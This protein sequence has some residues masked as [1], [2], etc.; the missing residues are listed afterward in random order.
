MGKGL[1]FFDSFHRSSS[2]KAAWLQK[3]RDG[4][5]FPSQNTPPQK[6]A[7]ML[8]DW[9]PTHL[10]RWPGYARSPVS[11]L[12]PTF[13]SSQPKGQTQEQRSHVW[14]WTPPPQL[15]QPPAVGIT[16]R[17]SSWLRPQA[18]WSNDEPPHLNGI[19]IK[20]LPHKIREPS[21]MVALCY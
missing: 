12:I 14:K 2:S 4:R 8:W 10:E 9:K 15:C 3:L 16:T 6:P 11:Q 21:E 20:F 18:S 7:V 5:N 1:R 17:K 13:K 19:L